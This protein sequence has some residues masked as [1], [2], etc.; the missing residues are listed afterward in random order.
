M[1]PPVFSGNLLESLLSQEDAAIREEFNARL[2]AEQ[3]R[4]CTRCKERWFDVE[5]FENGVCRRCHRK[6]DKKQPEEP[7]LY[8][9]ENNLDFGSVP[10]YLPE[11][12]PAEEMRTRFCQ[13]VLRKPLPLF[14]SPL[15]GL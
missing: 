10:D 12:L 4:Y 11:L 7:Y 13:R 14:P 8:S 5:P 1:P 9:A 6:D 15:T 3:M 2:A